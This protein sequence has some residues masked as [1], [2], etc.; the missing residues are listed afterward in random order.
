MEDC[1]SGRIGKASMVRVDVSPKPLKEYLEANGNVLE[2]DIEV[3]AMANVSATKFIIR[4]EAS[5]LDAD[6]KISTNPPTTL[7]YG[8]ETMGNFR[9]MDNTRG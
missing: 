6:K 1:P 8:H 7:E 2:P 5:K 9:Y 3:E 4:G